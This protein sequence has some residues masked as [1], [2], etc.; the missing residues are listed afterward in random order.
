MA[1]RSL[2]R[3]FALLALLAFLLPIAAIAEACEDCLWSVSPECCPPSCCTCCLQI[4]SS[5]SA[6]P[7]LSPPVEAG[8]AGDRAETRSLLS[9]PHDVFHVPKSPLA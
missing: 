7:D 5:L 3:L 9:P 1:R 2:L 8:P 6:M 4:P